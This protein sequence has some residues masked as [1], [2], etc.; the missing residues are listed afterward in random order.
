[1]D[2]DDPL[3]RHQPRG[4]RLVGSERR[5]RFRAVTGTGSVGGDLVVRGVICCVGVIDSG[6]PQ[7]Q[8]RQMAAPHAAD[9]RVGTGMGHPGS[10]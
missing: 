6:Q 3:A 8:G 9:C 4:D 10:Y 1:M 5:Q 2:R 7:G